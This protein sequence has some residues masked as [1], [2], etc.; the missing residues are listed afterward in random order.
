M[1]TRVMELNA[2]EERGIAVVRDKVKV[3]AQV[4]ATATTGGVGT[5]GLA[6]QRSSLP[7]RPPPSLPR[8]LWAAAGARPR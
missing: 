1:K 4:R 7:S 3:F 8:A 5:R 2:S 6:R